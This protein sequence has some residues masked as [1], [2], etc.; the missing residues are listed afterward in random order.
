MGDKIRFL[1][2]G[3]EYEVQELGVITPPLTVPVSSLGTGEVGY[4]L[5]AV[6][7]VRHARVGDTIVLLDDFKNNNVSALPGY[8][9][10]NPMVFSGLYPSDPDDFVLLRDGIEKLKLN[11]AALCFAPEKSDAFGAGFRCGFSGLLHVRN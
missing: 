2:S 5:A 9:E 4:L 11:D 6:R 3:T 1:G 7:D 8:A 10:P